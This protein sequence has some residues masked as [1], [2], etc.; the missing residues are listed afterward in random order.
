MSKIGTKYPPEKL[1]Y[2]RHIDVTTQRN[3]EPETQWRE[4]NRDRIRSVRGDLT[5]TKLA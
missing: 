5:T 2:W 3:A 4:Q 1:E